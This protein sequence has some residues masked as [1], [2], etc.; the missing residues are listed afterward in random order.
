M[1]QIS[2]ITGTDASEEAA[3]AM[4]EGRSIPKFD[5]F[6]V[7]T[8]PGS[9]NYVDVPVGTSFTGI[10]KELPKQYQATDFETREPKFYQDGQPIMEISIVLDTQYRVP[11]DDE[12]DGVRICRLGAQGKRALQD[13]IRRLNIKRF[14]IGSQ[15]TMTFAGYGT[16]K[17]TGRPPKL[18]KID[19]VPAEYVAVQQQAV[20]QTL[21][22]AGYTPV[23]NGAVAQANFP[24]AAAP[25][26]PVAAPVAAAPAVDPAYLAW[27]AQQAA[28]AAAPAPVATAPGVPIVTQAHVDKVL[29]LVKANID[30]AAAIVAVSTS[31]GGASEVFRA[32]L[33]QAVPV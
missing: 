19:L 4:L 12:D 3:W 1:V 24:V 31:D 16:N 11:G 33:D 26:V 8:P 29:M 15:F 27:Q 18:Y 23:G 17:G 14:G 32:A 28:A 6:A 30:R 22:A 9:R 2:N 5:K 10:V 21:A 13:E 7:E 20:E 25:A